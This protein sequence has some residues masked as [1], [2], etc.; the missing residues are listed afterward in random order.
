MQTVN[1]FSAPG[2]PRGMF[3]KDFTPQEIIEIA[4]NVFAQKMTAVLSKRRNRPISEARHAAIYCIRNKTNITLNECGKIFNRDHTT[5]IHAI[6]T[7]KNLLITDPIFASKL[8]RLMDNL[9]PLAELNNR[10]EEA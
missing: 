9:G 2:V 8:R 4:C 5:I 7:V 10:P 6:A 3:V 1:Y